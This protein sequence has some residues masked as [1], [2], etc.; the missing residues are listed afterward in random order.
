METER[1]NNMLSKLE[2]EILEAIKEAQ[3]NGVPFPTVKTLKN[4]EEPNPLERKYEA[5]HA[6][7]NL[8]EKRLVDFRGEVITTGGKTH[9][10]YGNRV[11]MIWWDYVE[12]N[13]YGIEY[14]NKHI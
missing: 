9:P 7:S 10:V 14:L 6:L 3:Y 13:S 5:A 8:K 11:A 2:I 1:G 12:I 4:I